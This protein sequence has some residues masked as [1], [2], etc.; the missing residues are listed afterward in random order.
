MT[1]KRKPTPTVA[2]NTSREGGQS[3]CPCDSGTPYTQCCQ[4][5]HGGVAAVSA[6]ALMRSRYSAYVLGISAYLLS[7]WHSSTRPQSLDL[8]KT[9]WL[10]LSVKQRSTSG[11]TATVEF[12]ARY[13]VQGKAHRLHERSRFVREDGRWYY[14]DGEVSA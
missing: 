5:L 6:D 13:K 2:R 7:T 4:P 1:A 12:V 9:H 11:D 8:H 14:V 10:G 3:P